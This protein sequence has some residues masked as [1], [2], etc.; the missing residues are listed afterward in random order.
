MRRSFREICGPHS[1]KTS[2]DDVDGA[3][4]DFAGFHL[5]VD[6]LPAL[7]SNML[8]GTVAKRIH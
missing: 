7:H 8:V 5:F 2:H 1:L 3:T 4:D 6:I